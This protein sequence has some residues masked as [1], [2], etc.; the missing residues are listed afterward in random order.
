MTVYTKKGDRGETS[1]F[2]GR[3]VSKA[4]PVIEAYGSLD[5]LS[6]LVGLA[7]AKIGKDKD[8]DLLTQIQK[9]LYLIMS[10]L[11]G[12]KK[13]VK[14]LEE[15]V[16]KFEQ[17]IDYIQSKL[18]KLTRF[19]L[20]QRDETASLF[21]ICRAVCRRAERAAVKFYNQKKK[22]TINNQQLA[23]FKYLNRLSDLFFVLARA[24]NKEKE[25]IT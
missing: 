16:K 7:R 11:A 6:S 15:R 21:H 23:I 20:P 14:G 12:A 2:G 8:K 18:P 5:E 13:E 22:S 1:L 24:Y 3:R 25:T 19:I 10:I 17:Y 4:D 9:D